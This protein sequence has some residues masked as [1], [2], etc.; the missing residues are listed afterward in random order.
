MKLHG[1]PDSGLRRIAQEMDDQ[2]EKHFRDRTNMHIELV[3]KYCE[4]IADTWEGFEGLIERG[5]VHDQ[6]KFEEPELD[7]YIWLTWR[8]KCK[9][10]GTECKMPEGMEDEI[11]E[12]TKHHILNNDHHPE[13]HQF[14]QENLFDEENDDR[15]GP[16][17]DPVDAS[18]MDKLDIG[19]MVADWCAM[20]EEL[21]SNTPREWAEDNIGVR[22]TFEPEQEEL[23]Y[24]LIDSVWEDGE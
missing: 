6:S 20:S 22:W 19:E 15:D 11:I 18:R 21:G 7:P 1:I 9:D 8:Y 24:T 2:I 14:R 12:A 3:Q 17:D 10:D 13:A 5:E 16:P 23:I 4:K